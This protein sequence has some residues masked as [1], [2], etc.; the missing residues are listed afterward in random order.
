MLINM[1]VK[2][3]ALIEEEDL[4]LE[5][6][7]NIL[8]GETGAGKSILIGSINLAMGGKINKELLREGKETLVELLFQIDNS[9]VAK[10][11]ER[12]DI[13]LEDG[14]IILSRKIS[15]GRSVCKINGETV[16]VSKVRD[17]ASLLINIYGQQEHETLLSKKNHL[18]LLDAYGSD[19]LIDLRNEVATSY[20]SY[21]RL[22]EQIEESQI[23]GEERER[24]ISFLEYEINEIESADLVEGEDEQLEL[25]YKQL[26]NYQKII[27]SVNKVNQCFNGEQQSIGSSLEDAIS[28]LNSVRSL[29][30]KVEDIALTLD[31]LEPLINDVCYQ[32]SDYISETHFSDED[33]YKIEHRLDE[34]NSLKKKYGQYIELIFEVLGQKNQRLKELKDYER[35]KADLEKQFESAQAQFVELSSELTQARKECSKKFTED[36]RNM[37]LELN[38]EQVKMSMVFEQTDRFTA[39][40]VDQPEFYI[41]LNAGEEQKPLSKVASGG[42]LSRIMLAI[43]TVMADKDAI[44]TL[45]FDE[46]DAGISGRTAQKVGEKMNLI[47]RQ[48]QV[49]AITHLPQ[50]AAMADT[51]YLIEKRSV[52]D[53]T[54]SSIHRLENRESVL[55]LARMLGGAQITPAV[56]ENATELKK[57]AQKLK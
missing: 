41:S 15:K 43:K 3:L 28:S 57:M 26:N 14:Q 39:K 5:E 42:E 45:I 9:D 6:G 48:T 2:N 24:E 19:E 54:I 46:I 44:D 13:E 37:L 12:L 16:T 4:S 36:I 38:F 47:G 8:T 1:H 40:G 29:D 32:L 22:K 55:E 53:N 34:I 10:L 56:I 17:V 50:I 11:L 25:N 23:S 18:Q 35:Y 51:H 20:R 27:E 21:R 33:F 31:E 52:D 30:K 49:I 7:V